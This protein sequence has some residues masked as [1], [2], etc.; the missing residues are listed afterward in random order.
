MIRLLLTTSL[1]FT[2]GFATAQEQV[3]ETGAE[4]GAPDTIIIRDAKTSD[5]GQF[6]WQKRPLVV[7][8]DSPNDPRFMQQMDH[9]TDALKD[10]GDRDVVVLTDTGEDPNSA[11]RTRLR[12][13]G[14]MLVL[15]AKDGTIYLRKPFPWDGREISRVI[16]KLP[17]RQQ[18]VRDRRSNGALNRETR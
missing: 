17:L 13:R 5:L 1:L 11:L 9:I 3:T 12:P 18:E 6:T 10:L 7:F 2:A 16:D 8:S 4:A 15:I 14:F